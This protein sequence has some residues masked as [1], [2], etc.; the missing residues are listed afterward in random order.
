MHRH[1]DI[2]REEHATDG[3]ASLSTSLNKVTSSFFCFTV[4]L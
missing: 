1:T 2:E 3:G 4:K